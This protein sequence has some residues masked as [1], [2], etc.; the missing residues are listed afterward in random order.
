MIRPQL[1]K[2]ISIWS[3]WQPLHLEPHLILGRAASDRL[4]TH[5]PRV[6]TLILTPETV[7]NEPNRLAPLLSDVRTV[8][9]RD[10]GYV[11]NL[12]QPDAFLAALTGFL[13]T[14]SGRG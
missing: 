6:P 8:V 3:A 13:D 4:K 14:V 12:E 11:S 7:A 2:M 9:I 10:A 1:W 5:P